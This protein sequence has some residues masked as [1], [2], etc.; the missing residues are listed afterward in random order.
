[1]GLPISLKDII[2]VAG[3]RT[4]A[5]ARA[6]MD[7]VAEEDAPLVTRLRRA[8]GVIIGKCNLHEWALGTTNEESAFGPVHN[9]FDLAR[10]PGGCSG[11]AAAAVVA[12]MGWA[13]IGSDTGGSIRIP[14]AACGVVG[15]KPSAR[16][17]SMVGVVPLSA[18]L[19][20]VGPIARSV[21]DAA[22]LYDVLRGA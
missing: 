6:R 10:S 20:H 9:P 17:I 11:G 14:A 2:D 13:S 5:A 22:L 7:H 18:S 21:S 1:H 12:S 15:L 4:T 19:D 3:V 8:G 16:E